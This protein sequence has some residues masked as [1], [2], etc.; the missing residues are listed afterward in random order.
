MLADLHAKKFYGILTEGPWK[1][2]AEVMLFMGVSILIA[3]FAII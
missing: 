2:A 1:E 3:A